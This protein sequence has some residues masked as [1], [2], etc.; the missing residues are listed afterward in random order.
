MTPTARPTVGSTAPG[1]TP[2]ATPRAT[3]A[4]LRAVTIAACLPYLA[5]KVA[6]IAGSHLGI[7][8]GS[9]LL[10]HENTM[11]AVNSLTVLMDATVIVLTLLLTRPWG[12]RVPAWLLAVPM[13]VGTGLLAPIV[14]GFP[15][16]LA[17]RVLGAGSA[18]ARPGGERPML[19]SWVW[20]VV[21]TGFIVQA[22]GLGALF[23]MYTRERW[24]P[25][26]R[27]RLGELAPSV[28]APAQRA[29]AIAAATLAL[30]PLV[31]HAL[32]AGGSARGLSTTVA[33][34]RTADFHV[35]E[36]VYALWAVCM[37]VGVLM[38]GLRIGRSIRVLVPLVLA[39]LGSGAMTW[40]GAWLTF[41]S[42]AAPSDVQQP[43]PVMHL[44]YA[45]QMITGFLVAA[46]GAYF[47]AERGAERA[48]GKAA[49]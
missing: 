21:Y 32:W 3:K 42:L 10:D 19:E 40:W 25:V 33:E 22:L 7:P 48:E 45:A 37:V 46:V 28:T 1:A 18:S 15:A 44:T 29:V 2:R 49:R 23:V 41:A 13:W 9:T 31:L 27:G 43:T 24:A 35:L 11:R 4:V 47:F 26:W 39:W 14:T 5:L 17:A 12:T 6:W 20:N 36:T 38:L 34:R 8:E 30:V 16:T